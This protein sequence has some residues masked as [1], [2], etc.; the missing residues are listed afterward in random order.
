MAVMPEP[1]YYWRHP[2]IHRADSRRHYWTHREES[3]RRATEYLKAHKRECRE[4]WEKWRAANPEKVKA[5]RKRYYLR[6]REQLLAKAAEWHRTHPAHRRNR[7]L[8]KWNLTPGRYQAL[9]DGQDGVCAICGK[10]PEKPLTVDH[11][12]RCCASGHSCCGKCICGLLCDPCNRGLGYL[13]DSP[14]LLRKAAEYLERKR[15]P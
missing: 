11:D 15:C 2:E 3:L 8:A 13:Q 5:Q 14:R 6:N 9:L 12:H 10:R 1:N 7:V 4:R